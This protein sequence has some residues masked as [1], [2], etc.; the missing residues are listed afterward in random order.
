M[1]AEPVKKKRTEGK[2]PEDSTDN[3][4]ADVDYYLG[5]EDKPTTSKNTRK[6]ASLQSLLAPD[7]REYRTTAADWE[8]RMKQRSDERETPDST[9]KDT[10]EQ[11]GQEGEEMAEKQRLERAIEDQQKELKKLERKKQHA[12]EECSRQKAREFQ[13][14]ITSGAWRKEKDRTPR[15][16]STEK[17]KKTAGFTSKNVAVKDVDEEDDDEEDYDAPTIPEGFHLLSDDVHCKNI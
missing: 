3:R 16:V 11:E 4:D 1:A 8:V 7:T 2:E 6:T 5:A 9:Q 17:R 10:E 15:I 13:E 14:T 12:I